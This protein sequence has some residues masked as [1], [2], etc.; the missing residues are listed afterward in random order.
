MGSCVGSL[1]DLELS[2][3]DGSVRNTPHGQTPC[4]WEAESC[5]TGGGGGGVFVLGGGC[6]LPT[7]KDSPHK[8]PKVA[9]LGSGTPVLHLAKF[10]STSIWA[11]ARGSSEVGSLLPH[12]YHHDWKLVPGTQV[13]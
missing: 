4:Y 3:S 7:T 6:H 12:K 13:A 1:P 5:C 2:F 10:W 9:G 11:A 8:E